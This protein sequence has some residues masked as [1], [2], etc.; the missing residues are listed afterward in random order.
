MTGA[1]VMS[2]ISST[3]CGDSS[4]ATGNSA[5]ADVTGALAADLVATAEGAEVVRG[6]ELARGEEA[7]TSPRVA[8][9]EL[10]TGCAGTWVCT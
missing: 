3:D 6:E 5:S 7:T 4:G 9:W 8:A 1:V 2:G 10:T